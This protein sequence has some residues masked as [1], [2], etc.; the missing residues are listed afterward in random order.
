MMKLERLLPLAAMLTIVAAMDVSE[1]RWAGDQKYA[2]I[3]D[4][5]P[6]VMIAICK[7][8]VRTNESN[9]RVVMDKGGV[10]VQTVYGHAKP[11]EL[12]RADGVVEYEFEKDIIVKSRQDEGLVT[13]RV[14]DYKNKEIPPKKTSIYLYVAIVASGDTEQLHTGMS[15]KKDTCRLKYM[16]QTAWSDPPMQAQCGIW[17]RDAAQAKETSGNWVQETNQLKSVYSTEDSDWTLIQYPVKKHM[18]SATSS[19]RLTAYFDMTE[20]PKNK[21]LEL[22]CKY[23]HKFG[24]G[25]LELKV[26]LGDETERI[27]DDFRHRCPALSN[28]ATE[29]GNFTSFFN[30]AYTT[31]C[32]GMISSMSEIKG[33]ISCE[34]GNHT[35]TSKIICRDFRWMERGSIQ[36]RPDGKPFSMDS[37]IDTCTSEGSVAVLN[38]LLLT[39]G[40]ASAILWR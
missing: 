35:Q 19:Y 34:S 12:S 1:I 37:Y 29:H 31:D 18:W 38:V 4:S 24:S 15:I 5:K 16:Q 25:K 28:S 8:S 14:E 20:L 27:M 32:M 17:Q 30:E 3:L 11:Y 39:V 6:V 26:D 7:Y 36:G 13:C 33:L 40:V 9:T 21:M 22:R 23:Y 10:H 2:T